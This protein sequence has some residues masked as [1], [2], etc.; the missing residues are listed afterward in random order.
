MKLVQQ[1]KEINDNIFTKM[2]KY[3]SAL[4]QVSWLDKKRKL[5]R[6]KELY[7]KEK[8]ATNKRLCTS[9]ENQ[10]GEGIRKTKKKEKPLKKEKEEASTLL[11]KFLSM[12]DLG[13]NLSRLTETLADTLI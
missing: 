13:V 9:F 3:L 4:K 12:E 2:Q 11:R 8:F 1:K 7:N 5:L 6:M 10:N